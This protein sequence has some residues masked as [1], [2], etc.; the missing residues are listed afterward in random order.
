M[1]RL[2]TPVMPGLAW[3][4]KRLNR[5]ILPSPRVEC[6]GDEFGAVIHP[7]HPRAPAL[8]TTSEVEQLDHRIRVDL[9]VD[10]EGDV[11]A[12]VFID[13]V[14]DLDRLAVSC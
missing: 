11:L 2:D 6:L 5:F 3:R 7:D 8:V 14:A 10:R 4:D 1:E 9:L 13:D 12:S